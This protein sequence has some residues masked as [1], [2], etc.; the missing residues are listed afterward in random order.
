T[1]P[2]AVGCRVM[3]GD[4]DHRVV[5]LIHDRGTRAVGVSP[6]SSAHG[7]PPWNI[8]HTVEDVG[9]TALESG[10]EHSGDTVLFSGSLIARL[11]R[12]QLELGVGNR[13]RPHQEA[14]QLYFMDGGFTVCWIAFAPVITHREAP[15]GDAHELTR[16]L[17]LDGG[18]R[19]YR[20]GCGRLSL[21][22]LSRELETSASRRTAT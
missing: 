3:P 14:A 13:D 6:V 20:L 18:I 9:A 17:P 12:E 4:M 10:V 22:I 1:R 11:L 19:D 15:R 5:C 21:F 7:K 8:C 16:W 2:G